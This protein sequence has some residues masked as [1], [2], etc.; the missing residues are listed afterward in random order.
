MKCSG[1]F[2]G[3]KVSMTQQ[4]GNFWKLVFTIITRNRCVLGPF[5]W[6]SV[7]ETDLPPRQL[8]G[9]FI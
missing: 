1:N 6:S 4:S 9:A 2:Y 3:K 7:P 5:I 8:Y